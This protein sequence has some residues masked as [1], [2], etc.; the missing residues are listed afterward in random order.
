VLPPQRD[1][2][3][4]FALVL[5][6]RRRDRVAVKSNRAINRRWASEAVIRSDYHEI[7]KGASRGGR[8]RVVG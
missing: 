4:G 6:R 2:Y 1:P 3:R 7:G 8:G 5:S